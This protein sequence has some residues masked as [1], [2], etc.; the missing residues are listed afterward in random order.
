MS[1]RCG[2]CAVA[3]SVLAGTAM[4]QE[5][6]ASGAPAAW[7]PPIDDSPALL[8][9]QADRSEFR[10]G[11]GNTLYLWDTQGWYG[12]DHNKF[13]VKAEGEAEFGSGVE[14][15]EFQGLYSR[16]VTS[17]FDL[18]AGI[19]QDVGPGPSPTYAVL[20][21][22]GLAP[23]WFEL[24]SALFLSDDG[25]LTARVEAEYDLLFTQ[26]LI[27]Q[28]R[29]EFNLAAQDVPELGIGAGLSDVELGFRLRYEIRRE[30]A[31]YVGVSW[32]RRIGDSADFARA[33]G[34]RAG[35]VFFVAGIRLWF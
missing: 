25:D 9:L 31:P 13:W 2:L 16:L 10:L 32:E 14:R 23:Y 27:G 34:S 7:T 6:P 19:R 21:F 22:Q 20:G 3:L 33:A 8:F 30:I 35:N 12:S 26:R 18:Q 17:F 11:R 24:D 15:A 4:A 1:I 28:S 29:I 5:Y